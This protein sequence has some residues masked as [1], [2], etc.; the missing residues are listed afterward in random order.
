MENNETGTG[1]PVSGAN[2]GNEDALAQE[3]AGS[4]V[5]VANCGLVCTKCGMHLKGKCTGCYSEKHIN[6]NCNIKKCAESRGYDTCAECK[7]FQNLKECGTLNN[8]IS[9]FFGFVFKTDKV[10]NLYRIREIGLEEFKKE[11]T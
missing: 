10:G 9:K 1:T 4:T 3:Q 8:F 2:S 6:M 7:D 11:N 5:I